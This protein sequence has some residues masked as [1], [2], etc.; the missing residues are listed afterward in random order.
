MTAD[1]TATAASPNP[2]PRTVY[3]ERFGRHGAARDAAGKRSLRLSNVRPVTFLAA[4]AALVA[5]DILEATAESLALAVAALLIMAFVAQV[6]VHRRVKREER[7][8]GALAGV[9][10][11]GLLRNA[12]YM[13]NSPLA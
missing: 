8:E 11:E 9:A 5:F 3:S 7:W 4:A 2:D 10:Q 12:K 13:A 1:T 6:I